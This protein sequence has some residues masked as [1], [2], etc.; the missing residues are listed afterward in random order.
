MY[1]LCKRIWTDCIAFQRIK[2]GTYDQNQIKWTRRI[3]TSFK[4]FTYVLSD[5][6]CCSIFLST[7]SW[8]KGPCELPP[9][10]LIFT[11]FKSYRS[12]QKNLLSFKASKPLKAIILSISSPLNHFK[13][14]DPQIP[15][16]LHYISEKNLLN[17]FVEAS[18]LPDI[19][20]ISNI[21]SISSLKTLCL[22]ACF[23]VACRCKN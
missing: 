23:G 12:L 4:V 6:L 1:K 19:S 9:F 22:R 18:L 10:L 7:V 20:E 2:C 5:T 13:P 8:Q 17:S 16:I 14:I 3:G 15:C 21:S 11:N